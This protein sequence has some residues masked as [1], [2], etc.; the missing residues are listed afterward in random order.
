MTA[1]SEKAWL[2]TREVA[3]YIGVTPQALAL[4]R[5]EGRGPAY[6]KLTSSG[7]GAVRYHRKDVDEWMESKRQEVSA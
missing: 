4:W 7:P 5:M 2:N 1:L 3:E 6:S